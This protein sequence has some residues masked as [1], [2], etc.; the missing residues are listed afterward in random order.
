MINSFRSNLEIHLQEIVRE[1]D[2][3][4]SSQGHFYVKQYLKDELQK[5]GEVTIHTFQVRGREHE[6]II[7]DLPYNLGNKPPILIGAHY[8]TVPHSP[9]ADDNG[10]GLAVL[11][12]LAHYFSR[13]T[14]NYPLRLVAFDMEE[15]GLW[16][17]KAYAKFLRQQGQDLRLMLSLEMLGYC[18]R[19][20]QSQRYPFGLKYFY[21][22]TADFIALIGNLKTLAD[23]LSLSKGLKT[24]GVKCEWLP[25]IANGYIVPDTTRSD[26]FP[27]WTQG[28][29]AMM[30]TDTANMRNPHYHSSGDT[31]ATLDLDFLAGV[32]QGLA[33]TLQT[34][35]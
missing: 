6:N 30:V 15:Y 7:V 8:D 16:G 23:L 25:V 31:I 33:L 11:L 22:D 1:R 32:C 2:P 26:H 5:W 29:R 10:T 34:L 28:Y 20:P 18:D 17:S 21:P 19:N 35:N 9:G 14:A 3:F 13:E 12:E 4:L 27:F 24:S